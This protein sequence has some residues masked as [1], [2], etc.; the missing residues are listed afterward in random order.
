VDGGKDVAI[1]LGQGTVVLW[2]GRVE[3]WL[4]WNFLPWSGRPE[5]QLPKAF[6]S[7]ESSARYRILITHEYQ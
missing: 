1:R 7:S 3:L 2:D 6:W 4:T 5:S